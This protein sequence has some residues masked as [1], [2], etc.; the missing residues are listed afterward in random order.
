MDITADVLL[1]E[2]A[3]IAPVMEQADTLERLR[4]LCEY[5]LRQNQIAK[6]ERDI[7]LRV[8]EQ[9]DNAQKEYYLREQIKAIQKELG[10]SDSQENDKLKVKSKKLEAK[11]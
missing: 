9:M 10:D 3:D 8:K 7:A 2:P 6:L 11:S 4:L 1:T 5:I